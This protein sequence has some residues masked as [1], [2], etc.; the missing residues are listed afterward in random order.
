[1]LK[2]LCE[3]NAARCVPTLP[4]THAVSDIRQSKTWRSKMH[5]DNYLCHSACCPR[6][7]PLASAKMLMFPVG[8][9]TETTKAKCCAHNCESAVDAAS[10]CEG[11]GLPDA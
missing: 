5:A 2:H 7:V 10:F 9:A 1:M 3:R 8:A 4:R 11:A 6:A